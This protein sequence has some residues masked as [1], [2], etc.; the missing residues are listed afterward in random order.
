ML[1][2]DRNSRVALAFAALLAFAGAFSTTPSTATGAAA[3]VTLSIGRRAEAKSAGVA[4]VVPRRDPF[5]GGVRAVVAP[6]VRPVTVP[7]FPAVPS[8]LGPLPPN[9]GARGSLFSFA[10]SDHVSAVVTGSHPVALI[11]D[12]STTRVVE[13][14]DRY[15]G[16]SIVAIDASGVHLSGGATVPVTLHPSL[17]LLNAG[18]RQP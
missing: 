16:A 17:P 11:D 2:L 5:A 13:V 14:G 15:D 18:A 12:G 10:P 7:V 3:P 4:M 8:A 9:A 1:T 6:V